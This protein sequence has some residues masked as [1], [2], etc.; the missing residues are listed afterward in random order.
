MSS[1]ARISERD[2][3][4][5]GAG[6]SGLCAARR[7]R[8]AGASVMVVEARDRV[9]GRTLTAPVAGG[10]V[11]LGAQW[12]GPG[13]ERALGLA[14]ELGVELFRQ[15]IEGRKLLEFDGE[16]RTYR[17]LLPR[18]PML[19]L[20][21]LGASIQRLERMARKIPLQDPMSAERAAELDAISIA[22]WIARNVRTEAART[23]LRIA[24]QAIFAIELKSISLL[25]FL[26][27]THA[28]GSF[29]RL[30][31]V[32]EGAQTFRL[33]GGAQQLSER[34]AERLGE[35][36]RLRSPVVGIE[37]GSE[38]VEL[39]VG[40]GEGGELL[41][42]RYSILALA[43]SLV[44]RIPI[45][46]A[47]PPERRLLGDGMQMGSV[48]KSVIVYD[49]PFW[50]EQGFSGEAVSS[51][52]P[53]RMVFDDCEHDASLAA[54]VAFTVGEDVGPLREG[55]GLAGRRAAVVEHLVQLFGP[56]AGEPVDY[57]DHD[58]SDDVW[59]GGG[60]AGVMPPRLLSQVGDALRAP[61]GRLHFAGTETATRWC[62][63]LDGAIEAGERAAA[64]I[65]AR[66]GEA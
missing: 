14:E 35:E 26:H 5:V 50:R 4:V 48:I 40:A 39:R 17:G 44:G 27:Y 30:A 23:M 54:L 45:A 12:L 55:G 53:L 7:L 2:V 65:I 49:R 37:Q 3:V 59:S 18:I 31:E 32:R 11:D 63:Y 43:P 15:H 6:L 19:A 62:G 57:V 56:E 22:E 28:G 36:L 1:V 61:V 13:Q 51:G 58:W 25:F 60:Y 52:A 46:P 20:A 16:L 24:I 10:S 34:L 64:E 66:L 33:K 21:D 8:E 38:G 41:R 9:G 42:C 47:L 29:T